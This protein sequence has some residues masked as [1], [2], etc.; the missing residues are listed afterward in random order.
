MAVKFGKLVLLVHVEKWPNLVS[1]AI[2]PE[3]VPDRT[4]AT[5]RQPE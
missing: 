5:H 1:K 3:R 2:K 4:L